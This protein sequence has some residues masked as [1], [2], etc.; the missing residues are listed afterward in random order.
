[1]NKGADLFQQGVR[2]V[3][4][5]DSNLSF[6]YDAWSKKGS[7][8][9]QVYGPLPLGISEWK[10]KDIA[11]PG[12]WRWDL[13]PFEL[14][15]SIKLE[16]QAIPYA[17]ASTSR[18]KLMWADSPRGDFSL[19]SAYRV[20][21]GLSQNLA[22]GGNWIWKLQTLPKIQ[23]FLWK[24][25]HNSIGV[26][27]CLSARGMEV[28][29]RCPWCLKETETIIHALRNCELVKPVWDELGAMGI[30]KEFFV[31]N[32]DNWMATNGKYDKALNENHPPWN[33]I[34]SFAVW[35][36]WKSRNQFVFSNHSQNPHMAKDIMSKSVEFFFCTYSKKGKPHTVIKQ[37][38]WSKPEQGWMKLNTDGSSLGNSGLASG[39]GVI[40]DWTSRWIVGFSR[41]IG[42]A[43]SLMAELWA[44][45]D[46]LMLCVDRNL[47]MVEIELDAKS[48]VDMLWNSN[49]TNNS[50]SPIIE[51]CRK[52]ISMIPQ[53]R[54]KHCYRE[55]N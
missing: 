48:V 9:Q 18:D 20:A 25:A 54:I 33:I 7:L 24:C 2:W 29:S 1:M 21:N 17:L 28:D 5:K 14:P 47:V 44:I 16:I 41:K 40:R 45:R 22:F 46:G 15:T 38:H 4:G 51:D 6:W 39:G 52:L 30:D 11:T 50:L 43:T 42:I 32:L 8:R 23:F 27:G 31:S 36:I 3:I 53:I 37:V 10:V 13:I 35:A 12:G 49:Y 34:F 19:S 55:A 26:N